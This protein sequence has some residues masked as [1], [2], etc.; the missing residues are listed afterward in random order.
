MDQ[1]VL[2]QKAK[3]GCKE[4]FSKLIKS[5]G[6]KIY[7]IAICYVKNED[8]ALDVVSEATFKAYI[9]INKLKDIKY[10]DTWLIRIVINESI[11]ALRKS[12]RIIHLEDYKKEIST[13]L[14]DKLE[15]KIDLYNALDKLK[16]DDKEI[17]VLKYFGD[18]TFGEIAEI[19]LKSENTIKTKHYRALDKVRKILEGELL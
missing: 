11:S 15:D 10:F 2:V 5:R 16:K 7:K 3:D 12:K 18:L 1:L 8:I 14:K 19:M 17:L 4:S 6:Q 9:N 13:E